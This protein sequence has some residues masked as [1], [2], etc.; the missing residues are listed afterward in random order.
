[1]KR[2]FVETREFSRKWK[3]L[4]MTEDDLADLQLYLMCHPDAG[5]VMQGTGGVRKVRWAKNK[6]KSGGIRTLY[7]DFTDIERIYLI[8]V[9]GKN[10][11]DNLTAAEKNIV[12][13]FVKGL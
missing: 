8:T 4:G 12:K 6:G 11:K 2:I 7:I 13:E 1:M 5:D 9:F 3:S 10:E